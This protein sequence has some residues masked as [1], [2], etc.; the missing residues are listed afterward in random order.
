M[1][2]SYTGKLTPKTNST[3]LGM[4]FSGA[5]GQTNGFGSMLEAEVKTDGRLVLTLKYKDIDSHIHQWSIDLTNE[6]RRA[7]G[8]MI[9]NYEPCL[10]EQYCDE[11]SK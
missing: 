4:R 10:F 2:I 3:V 1:E 7:L 6:Q 11:H 5:F 9:L 8:E